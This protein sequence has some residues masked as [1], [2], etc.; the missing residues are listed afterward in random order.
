MSEM[1]DAAVLER[2]H[3]LVRR[4]FSERFGGPTAP[5]TA[6]WPAIASGRD[7]LIA[8][9]T[10]SGKTLAAFLA[11][12]D[13]LLRRALAG[14]LPDA[15]QVVYISP[16]K[17][18]SND[19]HRNLEAPLAELGELAAREGLA[20]PP[21]RVMVR[22]GDTPA[23]ERGKMARRPP[24]ILVTTPESLYILLTAE[25][26][27][28]ALSQT[29]TVIVDEIHAVAGDKRGAHLALSLER[30]DRLVVQAGGARPVRVGLSATQRPIELIGRML[31]GAGR[32]EPHIVDA[33][34]ARHIDLALE[35]TDDELGAVA[36][37]EQFGRVYD[38]VV[39]LVG[40]HRTTLVFVNTR[41]LVERVSHALESRLGADQVVAHHGSMS[42]ERRLEAER[43]LKA[44]AVKCAVATASLELGIDVG[45]VDLVVQI[46]SPRSVA[47]L[48]QRIGRSGHSLGATPKGRLFPMTRDQLVEMAALC[49]AMAA[50][51]LDAIGLRCAPLDIL[52]QQVVA[53]AACEEL[54]EEELFALVRRAAQY[55]ELERREFDQVVTMLAEGVGSRHGRVTAHLLRDG[56]NGVIRAR[57]GAR[58]AAITCGGAI[59]DNASYSVVQ[60]PEETPVGTLDEDFA[61]ES[62]A[63]DI[64]LLG[65]TA[66]R[67]VRV[68]G[69]R[70]LVEDAA[71][72][73]PTIPFWLGEAPA[74]TEELSREVG[75]LRTEVGTA[76]LRGE[77]GA[78]IAGRI[79]QAGPV[80]RAAADQLVA[81]LAASQS[82]LGL[83]P[84]QRTVI[85]ERFFDQGGGMQLVLHAPFGGRINRAWGL[86]LRKRFCRSFNFELQAAATDEGIVLS[87]GQTHS[88]PLAEVFE[89][90]RSGTARDV[91]IQAVLAAPVFG[92]RWRWNT[93]RAL[94]VLRRRGGKKVPP[95]LLRMKTEDLLGLVFPQQ[96]ACLEN[97]VGDIELP[98]HPLVFETM[99]DCL[100]E[101]LDA[102]GLVA[103]L[104]RIERGE[105][106]LIARDVIEPS[107]LSHEII[108]ANP[109][110]Y[111]DDAPLEE[112][113]T[114]AVN[115]PRGLRAEVDREGGGGARVIEAA[116]VAQA[117]AEAR[118][119]VRDRD[120]LHDVLMSMWALP[121]A[122]GGAPA[123]AGDQASAWRA[124]FDE[125]EARGRAREVV[126]S[127]P[128]GRERRA[129]IPTERAALASA[130][131]RGEPGSE[132]WLVELV[133]AILA[134]SGPR[135]AAGLAGELGVAQAGVAEALL[136]L[137]GEGVALRGDF[138]READAGDGAAEAEVE[139]EA[140]AENAA[141]RDG[142]GGTQFCDRRMLARIHR[143]TI[144]RLR[145]EIEPVAPA[146]LM[147]FLLR[148]QRVARGSQ[149]IGSD[150][151]MRAIDQL[152]GFESAAGAWERE[153]LPAR[154]HAYEREW[155]DSLCFAG[156]VAWARLSPREPAA[157]PAQPQASAAPATAALAAVPSAVGSGPIPVES[158]RPRTPTRAAPL[159]LLLRAD[160]PWL[161]ASAPV[162][163]AESA[164]LSDAALA[165]HTALL[166]RGASFL[167][168]LVTALDRPPLQIEDALWELV[169]AGLATAD[170]FA[171]LRV[172]VERRRGESRSLF[173]TGEPARSR[174]PRSWSTAVKRARARDLLRPGHALRALPTS[175]GRWSLLPPPDPT[176]ADPDR[177]ARQLLCRYGVVF[178]DL[179]A[180]ESCLPP[181]RDLLV[182]LRRME[183][184][185]EIR[186][187][188][189]VSSFVGEQ[190]AL[191]EA[192]EGLRALRRAPDTTPEFAR[193]PA[194]DPL[195][196]VG[197]TS[198]GP[199]VP[200]VIGNAVLYRNGVALASLEAGQ[201][202]MRDHLHDGES[203]DPDLTYHPPIRLDLDSFQTTLPLPAAGG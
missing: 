137:E 48:L 108:N 46:G 40:Q 180:R 65:N 76:L 132:D 110:A 122:D 138:L 152:Q 112:R 162:A 172:L 23:G 79:A 167:A 197:I 92:V 83:L 117:E 198:P 26:S 20:M 47:T 181:W 143:L 37:H 120:E 77:G 164:G 60:V 174:A 126:W 90:L 85:A 125:L 135:T 2:F 145:R 22:T 131:L 53:M 70:V 14:G 147:R 88:F 81:Y 154:L 11:C 142:T 80:P 98:D 7:T 101:Y 183:A 193:V 33:G 168:D 100:Q 156:E 128:D 94:A 177:A 15:T 31:V 119:E 103:L 6:G 187:G 35:M 42:R 107:P 157:P 96:Q 29:R 36:S 28:A 62:M 75:E 89:F 57:R 25:R 153:I 51:R 68:E 91:L 165:V 93:T 9:P 111:L 66:W 95:Q 58:L 171:S 159:A 74:R 56:V 148:W 203:V 175:A 67:I 127:G 150:G 190:F 166:Q 30:L 102:D 176:A 1:C 179:L 38:R 124:W 12:L 115:L 189:F 105:I 71:G 121:L 87:L 123:W 49:R 186:G 27:R 82:A 106:D 144:G 114:R 34:W 44:G 73:A 185:G 160:L 63:G 8:A 24:H 64:F 170:G 86:A 136:R 161:R 4:W 43:R 72:Q 116:A 182:A 129:W 133:G 41:R 118:P 10:G 99:R 59:P 5:Q 140:E 169:A 54:V 130:A 163:P 69:S 200:A 55:S 146:A 201:L 196:L 149:L 17:A 52:A 195:N 3:P 104:E 113:R 173:D 184:R 202:V 134:Y 194:T 61:I 21:I 188:R 158:L 141:N 18:L 19:V 45:R 78:D 199:R 192:V 151:L 191:P 139:A 16:L 13:D 155:L 32:P 109:Y 39:D 178:R 50:G 97:V 84:S